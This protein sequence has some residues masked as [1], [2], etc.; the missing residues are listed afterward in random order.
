MLGVAAFDVRFM[1]FY[2]D[3]LH[4]ES[5]SSKLIDSA[6]VTNSAILKTDNGPR[7]WRKFETPMYR[8]LRKAQEFMERYELEFARIDNLS[9]YQLCIILS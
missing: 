1:S 7:L 3:E 6:F 5:R 4:S 8:K 2:F 9:N